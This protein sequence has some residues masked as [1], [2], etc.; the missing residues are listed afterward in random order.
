VWRDEA[1]KRYEQT[2]SIPQTLTPDDN[3]GYF[4]IES[5]YKSTTIGTVSATLNDADGS[6]SVIGTMPPTATRTPSYQ[7][8]RLFDTP[9]QAFVLKV[10]GKVKCDT[11]DFDNQEPTLRGCENVLIAF[12]QG[13]MLERERQYDKAQAMFAEAAMLLEQLK[14]IEVV[15]QAHNVRIIPQY[16]FVSEYD[17]YQANLLSF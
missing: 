16:G 2:G 17:L 3:A 4:E 12:A 14:R 1:G 6:T 5:I 15:Q 11:L 13:D 8:V 7:R 9:S 10:V